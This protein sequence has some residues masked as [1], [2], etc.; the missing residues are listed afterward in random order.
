M[1]GDLLAGEIP[2]VVL[3]PAQGLLY[4]EP[5]VDVLKSCQYANMCTY[6]A[7]T[8]ADSQITF[9]VQVPSQSMLVGRK[10]VLKLTAT[11]VMQGSP[12][13]GNHLLPVTPPSGGTALE[14]PLL[15]AKFN[16][17]FGMRANPLASVC[18][19]V[20]CYINQQSV[21]NE[22]FKFINAQ[23]LSFD[24]E[25]RKS[26]SGQ[27]C[28]P[29]NRYEYAFM[30]GTGTNPLGNGDSVYEQ[31]RGNF[32]YL[33]RTNPDAVGNE[34]ITAS[35]DVTW[36]EAIMLSPFL[37]SKCSD[38]SK[39][40]TG[41]NQ[42]NI[43]LSLTNLSYM[44]SMDYLSSA[45]HPFPASPLAVDINTA[46]QNKPSVQS[47]TFDQAN[48]PTLLINFTTPDLA[49]FGP[50]P[51][52]ISYD[53]H[54]QVVYTTD[55]GYLAGTNSSNSAA[56]PPVSVTSP[57]NATWTSNN[58]QVGVVPRYLMIWVSKTLSQ[59]AL[60][61]LQ[62]P[63]AGS[64]G[65]GNSA[66]LG[67]T[68]TDSFLYI[69]NLSVQWNG[70]S[71]LLGAADGYSLYQMSVRNGMNV[72]WIDWNVN[73][74]CCILLDMSRDIC[75]SI[76]TGAA[77]QSNLSVTLQVQNPSPSVFIATTEGSIA[78]PITIPPYQWSINIMTINDKQLNITPNGTTLTGSF[79][80]G[81]FFNQL[82]NG[83]VAK[84][85]IDFDAYERHIIGGSFWSNLRD[86]IRNVASKVHEYLPQVQH[87]FNQYVA[88]FLSE[89]NAEGV[90]N[91]FGLADRL[92]PHLIASG[93]SR[94]HIIQMLQPHIPL[95]QLEPLVDKFIHQGGNV[96][97]GRKVA[98]S[99]LRKY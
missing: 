3:D 19:N 11:V 12:G 73:G 94:D 10:L 5:K 69:N 86:K 92:L 72:K 70:E 21:N 24:D 16:A 1:S 55:M 27:G 22:S 7:N 39:F 75:T 83:Q 65:P 13:A 6:A 36:Y 66:I 87:G 96:V 56:V 95:H 71:S 57:S 63:P 80:P 44:L 62:A 41:I 14:Y 42:M 30:T 48:K 2:K 76:P 25:T 32:N 52:K 79:P 58:I 97:G 4:C 8:T 47:I 89:R 67:N 35:F 81:N 37:W 91:L 78:C 77:C 29:D 68:M 61:T 93:V 28:N 51:N 74:C 38:N 85:P 99:R 50:L 43:V 15:N 53:Y 9:N 54:E 84:Y 31:C 45:L 26:L 23:L 64:A 20:Q 46:M 60:T 59:R 18:S 34:Q 82:V 90:N 17:G 33:V 88:P 98:K 40:L 49:H